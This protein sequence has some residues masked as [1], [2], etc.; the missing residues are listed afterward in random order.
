MLTTAHTETLL[1]ACRCRF[2]ACLTHI[3]W[4]LWLL[5]LAC[6]AAPVCCYRALLE[7]ILNII[8]AFI[9]QLKLAKARRDRAMQ[10][11]RSRPSHGHA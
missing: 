11:K 1:A 6:L 2:P 5:V 8:L 3:A 10:P 4:M 7:H 9:A